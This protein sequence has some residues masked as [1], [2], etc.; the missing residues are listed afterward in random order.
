MIVNILPLFFLIF[1]VFF[2][3]NLAA[4]PPTG[5]GTTPPP[6]MVK[7]PAGEFI[8]G[9]D[10]RDGIIGIDV[11]VDEVPRHTV[12]LPDYYIDRFEIT[13]KEYE[14]FVGATGHRVPAEPRFSKFYQWVDG[15]PS[16][17]QEKYPVVYVDNNDAEAFCAW[18]GKRL[19]AEEEWEKAGRGT[20]GRKWPWGNQYDPQKCNAEES[21]LNWTWPVGS[22]P[23]GESPYGVM[24][25]CGNVAEWTSSWY[26]AY[27]GSKLDRPS[28]GETLKVVR[29]GAYS[30]PYMFSRVTHRT[31]ASPPY[32]RHRSIGFRCAL[33]AR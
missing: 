16:P 10:E 31:Y 6:G 24:D 3:G 11:G 8:M 1:S 27:P 19:P 28:F 5:P 25:M 15:H 4:E 12:S 17:G 30:L 29:G 32:K 18:R 2:A 33:D 20:D 22:H 9:S 26:K 14:A 23:E 7:I 21:R 13:N